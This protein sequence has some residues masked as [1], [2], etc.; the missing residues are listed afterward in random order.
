M[1]LVQLIIGLV[2]MG[3]GLWAINALIPMNAGIKKVLNVVV[4]IVAVLF[5]LSYFGIWGPGQ[6]L[7][8][9]R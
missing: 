5:A 8:V 7:L 1:T 4:I 9:L 3:V 2:I 6:R